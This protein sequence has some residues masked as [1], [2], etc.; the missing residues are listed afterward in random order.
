MQLARLDRWRIILSSHHVTC[1]HVMEQLMLMQSRGEVH[2]PE[3]VLDCFHDV[4]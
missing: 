3:L 2:A 4:Q 1:R